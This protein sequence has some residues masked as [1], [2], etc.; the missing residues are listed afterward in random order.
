MDCKRGELI[1]VEKMIRVE[2]LERQ[3]AEQ[4]DLLTEQKELL[5][6]KDEV[7]ADKKKEI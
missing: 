5:A 1:G 6:D 4:M 3:V 7:I 2:D